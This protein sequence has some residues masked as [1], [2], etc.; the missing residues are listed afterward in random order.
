MHSA[1]ERDMQSQTEQGNVCV[2]VDT[3]R[4]LKTNRVVMVG[5]LLVVGA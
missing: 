3:T 1:A 4:D 2:S 5:V